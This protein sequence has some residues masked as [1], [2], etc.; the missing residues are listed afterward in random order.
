MRPGADPTE[1][2]PS[3]STL[4]AEGSEVQG[5]PRSARELIAVVLRNNEA[6]R[7][8]PGVIGIWLGSGLLDG[9]FGLVRVLQDRVC[10]A[11]SRAGPC[12]PKPCDASTD[13]ARKYR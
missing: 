1:P 3:P 9:W 4:E 13:G 8:G 6:V 10:G 12:V 2:A 5:S 11:P 7:G